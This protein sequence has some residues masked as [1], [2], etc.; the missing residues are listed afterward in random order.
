M[1]RIF[2]YDGREF[3][4]PDASMTVDQVKAAFTDFM[5]E[6]STAVVKQ[7]QMDGNTIVEFQKR[8]GT[9]GTP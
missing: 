5:P 1:P 6:L 8:V 3:P 7:T 9:K 2:V 4:D